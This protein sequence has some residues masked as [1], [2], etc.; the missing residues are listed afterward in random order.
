MLAGLAGR[1]PLL[2]ARA[3]WGAALLL[4]PERVLEHCGH[5]PG[6]TI[7]VGARLLGARHLGQAGLQW[8]FSGPDERRWFRAVDL[9]HAA[10][11]LLLATV[12]PPPYRRAGLVSLSISGSLGLLD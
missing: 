10:T 3:A 11:M 2:S 9:S 7:R 5:P 6:R 12:G 8:H 1:P 4:A